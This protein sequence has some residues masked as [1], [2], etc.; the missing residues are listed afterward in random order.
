[1]ALIGFA[2]AAIAAVTPPGP[3]SLPWAGPGAGPWPGTGPGSGPGVWS[4]PLGS[5]GCACA[6]PPVTL[7]LPLARLAPPSSGT[8]ASSVAFPFASASARAPLPAFLPASLPV[9]TT[10]GASSPLSPP[11]LERARLRLGTAGAA[12]S[13]LAAAASSSSSM[14]VARLP[15][16]KSASATSCSFSEVTFTTTPP[17]FDRGF[18]L[19]FALSSLASLLVLGSARFSTVRAF[20]GTEGAGSFAVSS[21]FL[22][23]RAKN[24]FN[25]PFCEMAPREC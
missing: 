8:V 20:L 22:I 17:G 5:A 16:S 18:A 9:A 24:V 15:R 21:V 4:R 2:A 25:D 7:L 23:T 19:G 11:F 1:M 3:A 10:A 13:A 6:P 14:K 12:T